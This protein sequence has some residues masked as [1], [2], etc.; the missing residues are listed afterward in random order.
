MPLA[1]LRAGL[2][3]APSPF[4]DE[5]KVLTTHPPQHRLHSPCSL[6]GT[7][8]LPP[9]CSCSHPP[10]QALS[11]HCLMQNNL[12]QTSPLIRRL[13][14]VP[15]PCLPFSIRLLR[16]VADTHPPCCLHPPSQKCV[17]SAA[18]THP[19]GPQ[20]P[21]TPP[22]KALLALPP[23]LHP[24]F[25]ALLC[26]FSLVWMTAT[27]SHLLCLPAAPFCPPTLPQSPEGAKGIW[28]ARLQLLGLQ[29]GPLP[30]GLLTGGAT[31]GT[32]HPA[33]PALPAS[34]ETTLTAFRWNS[35][36]CLL[37]EALHE[38]RLGEMPPRA[39]DSGT[40]SQHPF[41]FF[42]ITWKCLFPSPPPPGLQLL[43]GWGWGWLSPTLVNL[44]SG[45]GS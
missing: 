24:G 35:G 34:L 27:A 43:W 9:S 20:I 32:C 39:S 21:V 37:E 11:R 5:A 17:Q 23:P 41:S 36:F 16:R 3:R 2:C 18:H 14:L 31:A 26:P 8:G 25:S 6:C 12:A 28:E 4:S 15:N 42:S 22:P 29:P 13:S 33:P 7:G 38:L 10:P 45:T 19:L 40:L 30:A 1:V 44:G